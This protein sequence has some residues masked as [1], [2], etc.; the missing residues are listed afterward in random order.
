MTGGPVLGVGEP[1]PDATLLD[2]AW[3]KV[4]LADQWKTAPAVVVFL[5][6]FGCPFC[7]AQVVGL[8]EDQD[9]FVRSGANVV[10]VGQGT[11]E[12]CGDFCTGQR[13]PFPVFVDPT[14]AAYAAYGLP[15]GRPMQVVGPR[16][17]FPW[18]ANQLHAE[19]RQRGLGGGSLM[20][21][22]G[23]FVIDAAGIVRLA[24]RNRHAA[25]TPRNSVLLEA[26][27]RCE[28]ESKA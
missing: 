10:I 17:A 3:G 15:R 7:Q 14:R 26:V 27:S 4:S 8:R 16:V 28:V 25:D 2:P 12:D 6:Y 9:R 1:A 22:P 20:Q 18:I 19:T 13:V 21:M 24:H 5:R 23:T 11:P